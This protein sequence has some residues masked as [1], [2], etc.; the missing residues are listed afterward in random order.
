M[1]LPLITN[2]Q[3]YSI[4][5]GDGIR[6]TVFFK[7]CN[8]ACRWCHNP[9]TQ[10]FGAEPMR[11]PD[12]CSGC[13]RCVELC[14]E[15][16]IALNT[17]GVSVTDREKCIRCGECVDECYNEARTIS[18][19]AYELK[20]LIKVLEKDKMY[21]EESGGGVT[22][23]GGEVMAQDMDYVAELAKQLHDRGHSV[24]IDTCGFAPYENYERI[25][26]YTDVFLY[27]IKAINDEVHKANTRVSNRLILD[28]LARLGKAGAK[29]YI[30]MPLIAGLNDSDEDMLRVIAFLRDNSVPVRQVN[31][32]PYHELGQDKLE[33]L[34]KERNDYGFSPPS[35]AH[36]QEL[37]QLFN[38][39]GYNNTKIGG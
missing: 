24:Y 15:H 27:D 13:G 35:S 10:E 8:M 26:P 3:R 29:I 23:S 25:L 21:W 22:L 4:H 14:P 31:L 16:A 11:N 38:Q 6:T 34:G 18:G 9:E 1:K 19:R 37:V 28:N 5:D 36:L 32:L 33:K 2:I 39:N 17:D 30:R 12:R 7:G 20:E